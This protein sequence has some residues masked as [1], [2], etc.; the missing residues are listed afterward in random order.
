VDSS[1]HPT[2]TSAPSNS[3]GGGG[4]QYP[5]WRSN[6]KGDYRD[7]PDQPLSTRDLLC[8]AFQIA[9]GMDY[10]ARRKVNSTIIFKS[11]FPLFDFRIEFKIL[12]G[13][14]AARNVL[15]ADDNIVKI[16][17]FGLAREVYRSGNYKKKGE[18]LLLLPSSFFL[19]RFNCP[20]LLLCV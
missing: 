18:V 4:G 20:F 19:L 8:W 14:L 5:P 6:Y 2:L 1:G 16:A 13:D 17:D 9:R 3:S 12:H 11:L 10:L 7:E 15:L